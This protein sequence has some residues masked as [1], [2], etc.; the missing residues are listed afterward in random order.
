MRALQAF[1][2]RVGL[3]HVSGWRYLTGSLGQLQRVWHEYGI[4]TQDLAG[5]A[6]QHTDRAYMIDPAGYVR[7]R[8]S[9]RPGPGTAV[10]KSSFAVLFADAA[11]QALGAR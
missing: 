4:T 7:R 9:T 1:D 2:R 5:A 3:D 8:Y 10:I 11:R 6:T